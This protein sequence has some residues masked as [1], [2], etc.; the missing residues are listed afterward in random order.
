MLELRRHSDRA[1]ASA[2]LASLLLFACQPGDV[3]LEKVTTV[4]ERVGGQ[5]VPDKRHDLFDVKAKWHD[6][7]L[8]LNGEVLAAAVSRNLGDSLAQAFPNL[9]FVDSI[10]VLPEGQLR[11]T[12]YGIVDIGLANQRKEA[13]YRAELVN[14]ATLGA[15]V[16][17]F[18]TDN[19]F[20]LVQNED[21]YLGWM[22]RGSVTL[23]D[24]AGAAAWRNAER[25]VCIAN[26]AQVAGLAE[27]GEDELL[28]DLVPGAILKR[29]G[30]RSGFIKV[31]TPDKR[32]GYVRKESLVE[33]SAL[34]AVRATQARIV[35]ISRQF[36]GAPYL[37]GGTSPKGFDCSGFV[38]TVFGLSNIAL[39]RDASQQA[40]EG[41]EV[42][43]GENF[44]ALQPGDL[45]F[46][47][48]SPGRISH[49][50]ISLG[51]KLYVHSSFSVHVNSLDNAH[52]L[53][54]DYRF[55]RFRSA[56]RLF[57]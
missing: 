49:V 19:G 28:V 39:P 33:E 48:D 27:T 5:L 23:V 11:N 38:Q 13:S 4:I 29:V 25:V 12:G 17:V 3:K 35:Q 1:L 41:R 37:W 14:Q 30:E 53:Y 20:Y 57:N 2:I 51:D 7:K 8:V 26:Y 44:E 43:P 40:K 6:S 45:I 32:T 21:R 24:S 56:K 22:S 15:V 34:K 42:D 55:R 52:P 16:R 9:T 31:E 18:K 46:F 47:G 36:L 50:G 10:R 54:N